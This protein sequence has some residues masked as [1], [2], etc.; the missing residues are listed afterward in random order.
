MAAITPTR[1]FLFVAMMV[2]P[3]IAAAQQEKSFGQQE[4][5][6][7]Q[8]TISGRVIFADTG[9]PVRRAT[10]TLYTD[11]KLRPVRTTAAN[12]RGEFRFS[13]VAAGSYFV[14][15]E[16]LGVLFPRAAYVA[17]EFGI[18]SDPEIEQ[19][20]VT[21][22]G[23][24]WRRCEVRVVR[25]GTIRGT[26]TYADKEPVINAKLVLSRRKDNVVVPFFTHT[27]FTN[28][29]GMYRIDG[30]PDGEYFLG[31]ITGRSTAERNRRYEGAGV[32]TAYYP[33]VVSIT[34]AKPIQI[35]SA[36]DV[37]GINIT[38]AEEP[39]RT[40]SGVV[41][42]RQ[43][44]T[45]A[46]RAVVILR[47]SD[48][49][50]FDLSLGALYESMAREGIQDNSFMRDAGLISR[51]IPPIVDADEEGE[52][53]FTD[54][55]PGEYVITAFASP[56]APQK[57]KGE[58]KT[59][60]ADSSDAELDPKR[61]VFQHV[62]VTVGDDDLQN[63]TIEL[64]GASRILGTVEA[65]G[66]ERISVEII[67]DQ[68]GGDELLRSIPH[69]NNSGGTFILDGI[70]TGEMI[71]DADISGFPDFYLKSIMFGSQDLMREPL[72]VTE[73]SE[74]T[75]VRITIGKGMAVLTGR[76]HFSEDESAVAGGGVL[77]VKADSKLWHLR[78]SHRFAMTNAAGEFRVTCA[79]GEY[80]VFTWPAG[81][82]PFQPIAAFV[83]AQ[84]STARTISLQSNEE[85]QIELTVS[86][87]KK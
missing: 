43:T 5:P 33:G 52:W 80:L 56:P 36:A 39:V 35:Q 54:L 15:A 76:L 77:L 29:L 17:N 25:A 9:R 2:L 21:V 37:A 3:S 45:I 42:W 84:A 48:E 26:I 8:S 82:Q 49:P 19:T 46:A 72:V 18:G 81:A 55:P 4:K 68:K 65:E 50:K 79:P 40:I 11:M 41:K 51:G 10:V 23:K 34:E 38:L 60:E 20:Q 57:G 70:P 87:P 28:D 14:V 64:P 61:I 32:T 86:K 83:R 1:L 78:S 85:K 44:G 27:E 7:G 66:S 47:R 71:L 12:L 6:V 63:V 75:G 74:V 73:G 59:A 22:D 62:E 16:E 69:H 58:A 30:L 13:E 31:V 53:M 24:N 67:V